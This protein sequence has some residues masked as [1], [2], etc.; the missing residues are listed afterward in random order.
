MAYILATY[1]QDIRATSVGSVPFLKLLGIVAGGW[2][3]ARA[4][5]VCARRLAE[6][7]GDA[8]FYRSKIVT[9]SFYA[10]HVLAQAPGLAATVI[11]GAAAALALEEGTSERV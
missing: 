10:D 11:H 4:A 7:P 1:P 2:Q 3:M 9:A 6:G 8:A 5:L